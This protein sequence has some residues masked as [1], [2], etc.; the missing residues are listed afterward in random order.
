MRADVANYIR[1]RFNMQRIF[2]GAVLRTRGSK[3][4][5]PGCGPH[6][7]Y[8]EI[9]KQSCIATYVYIP[10]Q[11]FDQ[12]AG[13]AWQT[14]LI[15]RKHA[16]PNLQPNTSYRRQL[17]SIVHVLCSERGGVKVLV[18]D[19]GAVWTKQNARKCRYSS[20]SPGNAG[21]MHTG[22]TI[23]CVR[24]RITGGQKNVST[25]SPVKQVGF[26]AG[27]RNEAKY[28]KDVDGVC[29]VRIYVHTDLT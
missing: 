1:K 7:F 24:H 20:A 6:P 8:S 21:K 15:R 19:S 11:H 4:A 25:C 2:L 5:S 10:K 28:S 29:Y 22:R 18:P 3:E 14:A 23:L 9:L 12:Q 27:A 17:I 26:S 16:D 13:H